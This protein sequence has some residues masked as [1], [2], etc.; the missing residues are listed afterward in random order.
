MAALR[1]GFLVERI[2]P[3]AFERPEARNRADLVVRLAIDRDRD[4]VADQVGIG[5]SARTVSAGRIC[6]SAGANRTAFFK[7]NPAAWAGKTR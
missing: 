4:L 7:E 5:V 3:G 1:P 6:A 2:P